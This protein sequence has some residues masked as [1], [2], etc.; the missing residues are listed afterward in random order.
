MLAKFIK[1]PA[2]RVSRKGVSA[3][4][5]EAQWL[6][7]NGPTEHRMDFALLAST[8]K[9]YAV[10][11]GNIVALEPSVLREIAERLEDMVTRTGLTDPRTYMAVFLIRKITGLSQ[12]GSWQGAA[13]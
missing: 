8:L 9:K 6:S 10:A 11:C 5:S 13:H 12:H 2:I 3:A 4:W 7:R 1:T